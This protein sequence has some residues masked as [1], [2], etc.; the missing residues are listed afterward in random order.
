ML[1]SDDTV[2]FQ[3]NGY[4]IKRNILDKAL[5]AKCLDHYW[6]SA[7]DGF[8]RDDPRTWRGKIFKNAFTRDKVIH[9]GDDWKDLTLSEM[10]EGKQIIAENPTIRTSVEHLASHEIRSVWTRGI[11]G[12]LPGASG[13]KAHIDGARP[14]PFIGVT[15][16]LSDI[17]VD[18]GGFTIYPRSHH[19]INPIAATLTE[20][21]LYLPSKWKEAIKVEPVQFTG[22]AGDIVFWHYN[23]VHL[24]TKN[25]SRNIRLAV[26]VDFQ[27]EKNYE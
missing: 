18:S 8:H 2:F 4:L 25:E 3:K 17:D 19:I 12:V 15:G 23:L 6:K 22:R 13:R 7:P 9:S 21:D 1:T 20:K 5:I 26:F 24:Y 11:F 27:F 16:L 10:P 14:L